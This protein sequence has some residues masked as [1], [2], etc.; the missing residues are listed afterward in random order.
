MHFNNI[1]LEAATIL[2]VTGNAL[3][4]VL[5]L[6]GFIEVRVSGAIKARLVYIF[7]GLL[8]VLG[9]LIISIFTL[10]GKEIFQTAINCLVSK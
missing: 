7:L 4:L 2:I 10:S 6:T 8:S 1:W 9:W 3:K 5:C